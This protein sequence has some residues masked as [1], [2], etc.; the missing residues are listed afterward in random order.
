[1][2]EKIHIE[3]TKY[4]DKAKKNIANFIQFCQI[5]SNWLLFLFIISAF[6]F[7][8]EL[9]H[10][11]ITVDEELSIAETS[12]NLGWVD[13][14][15]WGLYLITFLFLPNPMLPFLPMLTAL[16]FSA[17]AYVVMILLFSKKIDVASYV[18]APLFLSC[19]TLYFAYHFN[20]INF[21]FGIGFCFSSI[22]IYSIATFSSK[23]KYLS[24]FL[25]VFSIGI[26]QGFVPFICILMCFSFLHLVLS[27]ENP[28]SLKKLFSVILENGL[29]L[30]MAIGLYYLF[31]KLSYIVFDTQPN[32]YVNSYLKIESDWSYW[33]HTFTNVIKNIKLFYLG[34]SEIYLFSVSSLGPLV[35]LGF[36]YLVYHIIKTNNTIPVKIAVI[37]LL[38]VIPILPFSIYFISG[39]HM[40]IRTNLGFPIVICF[41]TFFAIQKSTS[42]F[43]ALLIVLAI[44]CSFQF[45]AR[46]HQ[47]AFIN[48]LSWEKDREL[49][50]RV[51]SRIDDV[52]YKLPIIAKNKTHPLLIVG[53]P[54]LQNSLPVYRRFSTVG[55]SF[56]AMGSG[57]QKNTRIIA[58]LKILG[59]TNFHD[60]YHVREKKER[61]ELIDKMPHWPAKGSVDVIKGLVV[62]KF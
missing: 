9:F 51:M 54:N 38:L 23:I 18:A 52:Y 30:V 57:G 20:T 41:I 26:Y 39:G 50:V 53:K 35:I 46:N 24:I 19:T 32:H 61:K 31:T 14:G 1:M 29:I 15:R 40:P 16:F 36:C 43:K 34:S 5:N 6:S 13:Q 62:I 22:A 55:W 45:A 28:T 4:I 11:T 12:S 2:E 60:G 8:Y 48:H 10:L 7:S 25:L 44:V 59:I 33:Q 49:A 21:A 42:F 58:F 47:L 17:M 3:F 56:W 37:I 27:K